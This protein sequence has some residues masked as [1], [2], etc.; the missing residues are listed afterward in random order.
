MI[1]GRF[2][3]RLLDE[4]L[5]GV[6][7]QSRRLKHR[8]IEYAQIVGMHRQITANPTYKYTARTANTQ[9]ITRCKTPHFLDGIEW[10]RGGGLQVVS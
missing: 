1:D 10:C 8:R 5:R 2:A 4:L 9:I 6:D 7:E 3:E